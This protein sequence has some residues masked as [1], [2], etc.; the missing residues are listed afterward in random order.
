MSAENCSSVQIMAL[1][2]P[3][4]L[5]ML[6]DLRTDQLIPD[7]LLWNSTLIS[8]YINSYSSLSNVCEIHTEDTF[9]KKADLLGMDGHLK[10]SV[11]TGLVEVFRAAKL[12]NNRQTTQHKRR[13]ILKYSITTCRHELSITHFN[14]NNII[15]EEI[16]NRNIATHV[17]TSILY[18]AEVYFVFERILF[19]NENHTEI[20]M[21]VTKLLEKM[22]TLRLFHN[23]QLNLNDNEKQV[24]QSLTCQYYGDFNL[25]SNPT[26]FYDAANL[27]KQ[28]PNLLND[29][30]IPKQVCLYPLHALDK[31]NLINTRIYS[32]NSDLVNRSIKL[33]ERLYRLEVTVNDLKNSLLPT[34]F[35]HQTEEQLSICCTH[36]HAFEIAMKRKI[37]R[38]LCK[39]RSGVEQEMTLDNLLQKIDLFALNEKQLDNWIR[40]TAEQTKIMTGFFNDLSEQDN[41]DIADFSL[42]KDRYDLN[43]KCLLRLT[44]HLTEKTDRFLNKIF[45]YLNDDIDRQHNQNINMY[46]WF[47]Q[48]NFALIQNKIALFS[49][50][51]RINKNKE[52]VKFIVEQQYADDFQMKKAMK[53][54][55]TS[56][57]GFRETK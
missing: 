27:F 7:T 18:G 51:A 55:E 40:L 32:I 36:I 46:Y 16:F 41:T 31:S 17:V 33:I 24:A 19:T 44:I 39:I 22:T 4:Q 52:N 20:D 42:V 23:Y 12:I 53:L 54:F 2:R 13:F 1:G 45:E 37:K 38:V 28:L 3:I 25:I 5:G 10:M 29:N 21:I 8:K 11:L 48:D 9:A 47:N 50:F 30:T 26:T 56:V 15:H 35:F 6:Y 34:T 43:R 14:K 49:E 57:S